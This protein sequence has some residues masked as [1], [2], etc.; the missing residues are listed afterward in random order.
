MTGAWDYGQNRCGVD[1]YGYTSEDAAIAGGAHEYYDSGCGYTVQSVSPWPTVANPQAKCVCGGTS[2]T[3]P[4]TSHGVEWFNSTGASIVSN[5]VPPSCTV[6]GPD[7]LCVYRRRSVDCP[8]GYQWSGDQCARIGADP[9]KNCC[10]DTS[11]PNPSNPVHT[12]LGTKLQQETDIDLGKGLR[13]TRYYSSFPSWSTTTFGFNW[14]HNFERSLAVSSGS[15]GFST[16]WAQRANGDLYAFNLSSA[17]V[18]THDPDLKLTLAQILDG[19]GATIGWTIRDENDE[20]ETYTVDG[21]LSSILVDRYNLL[22]MTYNTNQQ[23]TSVANSNGRHLD[24]AYNTD[25]RITTI[26]ASDGTVVTYA[27]NTDG[28]LISAV[29]PDSTP[30]DPNDNPKRLYLYENSTSPFLHALTGITDEKSQRYATW[31]YESYHSNDWNADVPRATLSVHGTSTDL[32]DRVQFS[33]IND[34]TTQVTEPLGH[35]ITYTFNTIYGVKKLASMSGPCVSCGG[36]TAAKTYDSNGFDDVV[37]DFLGT[38]TDYNYNTRGLPTQEIDSTNKAATKRTIQTDW[39]A[40]FRVPS[41]RRTL[42]ASGTLISKTD[43]TYNTRGQALTQTLIDPVTSATR[44]TT[45]TYCEQADLTAG[46]CPI[47]GLLKSIDGPRT[48]ISDLNTYTYYQTDD[49]T[50]VS[51]PTTCPHRKGDLW[52]VTNAASQV[53][54][55]LK[56]DGAGRALSMQDPN[57][58]VTDLTYN[59]RG[60]LTQRAVRGTDNNVTTDDNSTTYAYDATGQ[61]TQVTQPDNSYVAFTY[62]AAHRLTDIRDAL[63]NNIHY[64]LD[65]AGNRTREDT[66]V[67]SVLTRTLS[68][69]YDNMGLLQQSLNAQSV[70]TQYTYDANNNPNFTT[71]ALNRVTDQDYDPLNR[72]MHTLQ[73]VGGI[74]ASTSY[75]YD[76]RDH[77]TQ[78]TDPKGLNTV[79]QYDGLDNLTRLTSPDTGVTNY[80]LDVAGNRKTQTDA[81][82]VLT[83]YSYDALNRLTAIT[84]PTTSLNASFS[85]DAPQSPTCVTGETFSIGRLTKFTDASGNTVLCYDRF[86][87]LVR[88]VQTMSSGLGAKTFTTQYSYNKAGRIIK[89]ITPKTVTIDYTRDAA[90]RIVTVGFR[91]SGSVDTPLINNVTYYAFGPVQQLAYANGRTLTRTYDRDYVIGSVLS[92]GSGGLD[93]S[94]GRD[95]VGNLTQ[96]VSTAGSNNFTYDGLDRLTAVNALNG[97]LIA[98]Y[99]YD[100]TGNRLSKQT[101]GG[102]Q[103]YV[104]PATS[105]RLS[106]VAS[107]ARTYNA[108]GN[109]LTIANTSNLTYNDTSRMSTAALYSGGVVPPPTQFTYNARGERVSKGGLSANQYTIYDEAGHVLGDYNAVGMN[110]RLDEYVWLDDLPV[111]VLTGTAGT[112]AY[113][114]PDHLGT[115]RVAVD[116]ARNVAIWKWP[117]SNDAFGESVPQTDPDADGKQ[118]TLDLRLP[119]QVWTAESGLNYNYFR[120]YEAATGRYVESDPIG[121]WGGPSTYAYVGDSPLASSDRDGLQARGSNLPPTNYLKE[122]D[123]AD[124]KEAGERCSPNQAIKCKRNYI[125]KLASAKGGNLIYGYVKSDLQY[126]CDDKNFCQRNPKTCA[127]GVAILGVAGVIVMCAQPETIPF[128]APAY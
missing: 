127:T 94:F 72:L 79:Y 112:L 107:A 89:T 40:T 42:D 13:L 123:A 65:A 96:L 77:L 101:V 122:C 41:E 46:T 87:N 81:R 120:D 1:Q 82:N 67:A 126:E 17:G 103:A 59:P 53:T 31:A 60:W 19:G 21:V 20:L 52:K 34:S 51:A 62:D 105:H 66:K 35:S 76:A 61:V 75:A 106:S 49:A 30:S 55:F 3:V 102:T 9:G 38:T 64:T 57:G 121:L 48:D 85:Y 118:L 125:R 97:T 43:W 63:N 24:F 100:G 114:E 26:T 119:G 37:T 27:Y 109:M 117:L 28:N 4:I 33:F 23:L 50:C 2:N 88:K 104:Y 5:G 93:Y 71:D 73:N 45:S 25:G 86:G 44:T 36:T 7:G 83:G 12:A 32:I 69:V 18:I 91:L 113:L 11:G 10:V 84:Y 115:P 54:Q 22:T 6:G 29:Y 95:A 16:I 128:L 58:V 39:D 70:A 92:S 47:I 99:T 15:G 8:L 90:D 14:R 74:G 111:A 78:V 108:A 56:Y 116:P 80:T 124:W 98:A 110:N 68:R